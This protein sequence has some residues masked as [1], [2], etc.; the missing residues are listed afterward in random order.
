MNQHIAKMAADSNDQR[1]QLMRLMQASTATAEGQRKS[2]QDDIRAAAIIADDQ[3]AILLADIRQAEIMRKD[4]AQR[5]DQQ[6][7]DMMQMIRG[8]SVAQA[9]PSASTPQSQSQPL[10][11]APPGADTN[12]QLVNLLTQEALEKQK[13]AS[14]H[15]ISA[16]DTYSPETQLTLKQHMPVYRWRKEHPDAAV[17]RRCLV[18]VSALVQESIDKKWTHLE[19]ATHVGNKIAQQSRFVSPTMAAEIDILLKLVAT[20][21]GTLDFPRVVLCELAILTRNDL[22]QRFLDAIRLARTAHPATST[23][24]LDC[25]AI[26]GIP[27]KAD[28]QQKKFPIEGEPTRNTAG[29]KMCWVCNQPGYSAQHVCKDADVL[30]FAKNRSKQTRKNA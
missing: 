26:G 17:L 29:S 25:P 13:Y 18:T 8:I 11:A 5:T 6:F 12:Q 28:T 24:T 10:F 15:V 3:R 19:I 30:A 23:G 2:L 14:S 9:Q 22:S 27:V 21:S 1:D 7:N 20:S 16:N 4:S